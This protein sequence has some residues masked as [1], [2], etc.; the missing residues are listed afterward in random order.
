MS[1]QRSFKLP[2]GLIALRERNYALYMSG[3][4][5]SQVGNWLEIT[6]TSWIIYEMTNS[7]LL[8]GLSALFR[9]LPTVVLAVYGGA[10]VDRLPRRRL[11]YATETFMLATSLLMCALAASGQLAY[12]HL[13]A[14]NFVSGT[15]SA[16]GV[17]ARH[18]L[19]GGLVPRAA[20]QS[21][22]TLN[23]V[24]VRSGG[25]V[26]PTI[27]GLALTFGGYTLP[28]ALNALS[29]CFMLA[30]L[31]AMRLD[32]D[33][34]KRASRHG[35]V[36]QQMAEGVQFVLKSP[37]LRLA[38]SF[39]LAAGI[40]GYNTTLVT[41]IARDV[42]GTGPSGMGW[43]LSAAGAGGLVAMGL[44]VARQW[45]NQERLMIAIGLSY[46]VLWAGVGLSQSLWLSILLLFAL[47]I[48]DSIWGVTRNS[49]AQLTVSDHMRGRVMSIV[50]MTTRG[51]SQIGRVQSGFLVGLLGAPGAVIAGAAVIGAVVATFWTQGLVNRHLADEDGEDATP[52]PWHR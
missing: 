28:F 47:G 46:V 49:I 19:F 17:P 12:W 52:Y 31:A 3:Q 21:A 25:F 30:A 41:I 4:F 42:L 7:P 50:M 24:A 34:A 36:T 35:A 8:L 14:L 20:L 10:I 32:P 9:V 22:V 39:E 23:S 33:D 16:F 2:E 5:A 27:A 1:G 13:Y 43:M 29:F 26:G 51:S 15:V 40:F 38:L 37:P 44:M 48:V 11:L 6:A 45:S 18:A